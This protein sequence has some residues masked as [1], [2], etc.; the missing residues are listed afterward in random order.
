MLNLSE[1]LFLGKGTH[2]KCYLH[3]E[4]SSKCIKMA[5]T[6]E[7]E[8]DLQRELRYLKVL[9]RKGKNYSV[10]PR[11]YGAV[12]TNLGEGHVYEYLVNFDGSK[13]RTLEDFLEDEQMLSEHFELLVAKLRQLKTDLL[14]NEIITM[15]LFPENIIVQAGG[16]ERYIAK[17]N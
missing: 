2:K 17:S 16:D 9:R 12:A 7:G 14:N 5:Y 4:D 3:P 15:G 13:C 11:Y 6:Y 10:L 1:E 8:D